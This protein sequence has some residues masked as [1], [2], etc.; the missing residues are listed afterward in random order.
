VTDAE[1]DGRRTRHVDRREALLDA[2]ADYVLAHGLGNLSIRPLS[3]ALGLSHRTLLYHFESKEK[4]LLEV[5]DVIRAR[6][7]GT[8]RAYLGRATVGSAV[9][10]FR[11]AWAYFSAPERME[12]IRFFH[13]VFALGLQGPPYDAWVEKVADSRIEMI[14]AALAGMGVPPARA[15]PAA[16]LITAAVRGLQLHLLS[17]GDRASTDAAFEELLSGLQAQLR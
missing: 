8:I 6:D 9:D 5:L 13:E 10:L 15:Q 11:A 12:Y 2:A 3:A 14:A 1:Q 7:K 4:L 17:T 16:L